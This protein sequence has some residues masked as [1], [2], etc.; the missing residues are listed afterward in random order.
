VVPVAVNVSGRQMQRQNL[1][2]TVAAA[3]EASGV[4]PALL[5]VEM[6]ESV[7]L[8]NTADAKAV[9]QGLKALGL[10][11]A[12]DDFG[13]GYS[14]LSYLK[15]F[16][17]DT[18]KVDRSFVREVPHDPNDAAIVRAIVAMAR[19]LG[20]RVVA[21]GV[22]TGPQFEFLRELGCHQMQGYL[23]SPPVPP[24]RFA[25][26]LGRRQPEVPVAALVS[27]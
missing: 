25:A 2:V 11:V 7:L 21:E 20:L 10:S 15:V 27:A 3:I 22:E 24:D 18:L 17:I 5:E 6:T 4:D 14:S 26:F 1:Y 9:L 13:T 16:P 23:F 8:E 12:I 19:T